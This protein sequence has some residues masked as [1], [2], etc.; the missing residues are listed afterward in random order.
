MVVAMP[1][2]K[3]I[4]AIVC[5]IAVAAVACVVFLNMD[6]NSKDSKSD[7]DMSDVITA[8]DLEDLKS[9]AS[10]D[11]ST[12]LDMSNDTASVQF[13][14]AAILALK[15]AGTFKT[16]VVD[17]STL[18]EADRA[19]VGSMP[20]YEISFGTNKS[21]GEG[22]ARVTLPYTPGPG[23]D[24]GKVYVACIVDGVIEKFEA[25]YSDGKV[26]FSTKHFSLFA[27]LS[28]QVC[29][30]TFTD[31]GLTVDTK[32]VPYGAFIPASTYSPVLDEGDYFCGWIGLTDT[33]AATGD[34]SFEISITHSSA[35]ID[36]S[37]LSYDGAF[38]TFEAVPGATVAK[39]SVISANDFPMVPENVINWEV[40]QPTSASERFAAISSSIRAGQDVM[41]VKPVQVAIDGYDDILVYK[42]DVSS[43]F[44]MTMLYFVALN[45]EQLVYTGSFDDSMVLDKFS[46]ILVSDSL[47]TDEDIRA[48]LVSALASIGV[49][50]NIAVG[51]A[52]ECAQTFLESYSGVFGTF[53]AGQ[54]G[55]SVASVTGNGTI[56]WTV[57]AGSADLF[58][59]AVEAIA[60]SGAERVTISGYDNAALFIRSDG[61]ALNVYFA[62]YTDSFFV[63][64]TDANVSTC[65]SAKDATVEDASILF[66]Y[67]LKAFGVNVYIPVGLALSAAWFLEN[68]EEP[69][70]GSVWTVR[71]GSKSTSAAID[72]TVTF[73][74]GRVGHGQ[75][76]FTKEDNINTAYAAAVQK[77]NTYDGKAGGM[78]NIFRI[79][80]YSFDG[81]EFA[82]VGYNTA[83]SMAVKFVMKV[84]DVLVDGT[85]PG[86]SQYTPSGKTKPETYQDY[87]Y[88][89]AATDKQEA[90]FESYLRLL[91]TAVEEHGG[92]S[93]PSGI[94][95][96]A[97]AEEFAAAWG[98]NY[99]AM[100]GNNRSSQMPASSLTVTES[101]E[102]SATFKYTYKNNSN[103]E[104]NEYIYVTAENSISFAYANAKT[105]LSKLDGAETGLGSTTYSKIQAEIDGVEFYGVLYTKDNSG[106]GCLKFVTYAG[107][108]LID[109]SIS[110][111]ENDGYPYIFLG[112]DQD[113]VAAACTVIKAFHD[114]FSETDSTE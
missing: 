1:N 17:H 20:V 32:E 39:A 54:S 31:G 9:K 2:T 43:T 33:T 25:S 29:T 34:A 84:G 92:G 85:S 62:A 98:E 51:N 58:Q 67:A 40:G 111:A 77:L 18:S 94:D 22:T 3:I 82:S 88:L 99:G 59:S 87:I 47:A 86:E 36:S 15:S 73:Y 35:A 108:I 26:T 114:A 69:Y 103:V 76:L 23:E 66:S 68:Y 93:E 107:N 72:V 102:T 6:D 45:G 95:V 75:V 38:G 27:V 96:G 104:R 44:T 90:F 14:S 30:I 48:V 50:D 71:D 55:E 37:A 100:T 65:S 7:T 8:S 113:H 60:A 5:V 42:A 49:S 53:T 57:D 16:S 91:I 89:R 109:A 106:I 105:E 79:F 11:S 78:G 101:S 80:D 13:N 41:G 56:T 110:Y 28:E 81:I 21:F 52:A 10:S 70:E 19:V 64:N 112:Y 4:L 46:G 83:T 97:A 61:D 24:T 63:T 12:T 74:S